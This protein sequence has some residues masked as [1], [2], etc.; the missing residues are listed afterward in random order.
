MQGVGSLIFRRLSLLQW[1]T[2]RVALIL[3]FLDLLTKDTIL[4]LILLYLDMIMLVNGLMFIDN[5]SNYSCNSH[6]NCCLISV[7]Q[8]SFG[9][10]LFPLDANMCFIVFIQGS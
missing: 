10:V 1:F 4:L 6:D 7:V 5:D 9:R 3:H 2:M 8:F